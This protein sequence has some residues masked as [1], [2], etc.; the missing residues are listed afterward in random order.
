M[1]PN[2]AKDFIEKVADLKEADVL[3]TVALRL[4]Q[5]DDPMMIIDTCQEGMLEVGKRYEK[6]EYYISSLIVA[7]EL[8]REVTELVYPLIKQNMKGEET[9][10]ILLGTVHGDIHDLGKNIFGMMMTCHGFKV[11]DIGVDVPPEEFVRQAGEK[12]P[13]IIGLSGLL[14]IAF[15]S[16]RDTVGLIK[17]NDDN[18]IASTPI[19]IGSSLIKAETCKFIGADYWTR[20]AISG[21]NLCKQIIAGQKASVPFK[22]TT[23]Q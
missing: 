5:G 10:E 17:K 3:S 22:S 12:R 1:E 23:T 6:G 14:T 7:G 2:E 18:R 9:G 20:S 21:V 8:F 11:T 15:D 19:I 13:D 16:M 4:Q